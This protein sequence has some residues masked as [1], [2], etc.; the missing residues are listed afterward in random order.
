[1]NIKII[2]SVITLLFPFLSLSQGVGLIIHEG[3][4]MVIMEYEDAQTLDLLSRKGLKYDTVVKLYYE[5]IRS[6][7]DY[8]IL[9]QDLLSKNQETIKEL[10]SEVSQWKI[11]D[12]ENS[13]K[14]NQALANVQIFK[15]QVEVYKRQRNGVIVI[16]GVAILTSLITYQI[17]K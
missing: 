11:K 2:I 15:D 8:R 10:E 3:N 13:K 14:T 9:T 16:A 7:N 12:A 4:K 6:Y 17:S 1:M 5:V